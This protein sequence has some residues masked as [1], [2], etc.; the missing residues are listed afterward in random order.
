MKTGVDALP[1]SYYEEEII[2]LMNVFGDSRPLTSS[3]RVLHSC[4]HEYLTD[5]VSCILGD[6]ADD[7]NDFIA[8]E[9]ASFV[10]IVPL[11]SESKVWRWHV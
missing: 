8:V 1:R 6:F 9:G 2:T 10:W 11:Y 4:V 5:I 7:A 3:A